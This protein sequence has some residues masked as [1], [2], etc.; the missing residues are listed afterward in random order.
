MKRLSLV[1][2][3]VGAWMGLRRLYKGW[4]SHRQSPVDAVDEASR[5]S[6]PASDAPAW[7]GR[8]R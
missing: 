6:F 7:S 1:A 2:L 5:E 8:E 4:K 3:G